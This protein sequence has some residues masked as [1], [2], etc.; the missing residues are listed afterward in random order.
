MKLSPTVIFLLIAIAATVAPAGAAPSEQSEPDSDQFM[1]TAESVEASEGPRGRVVRLDSNVTITRGGAT[2]TGD[3]GVYYEAEGHAIVYGNVTG[4]DGGRYV[5]CDTLDYFLATDSV[6][7]RGNASYSD[8]SGT[9]TADRIRMLRSEGVAVC[10][11]NVRSADADG[12]FQLTAGKLVYDFDAG[13]GRASMEPSLT[14][15]DDE[16]NLDASVSGDVIEFSTA[17]DAAFAFGDVTMEREDITARA[18][19]ASVVRDGGIE[20][21][22]DPLVEQ[23]G[24]GLTGDRITVSTKDGEVSRVVSVGSAT[25]TYVIEPDEAGEAPSRG[26]VS[27]DTLTMFMEDGTPVLTT[28]RGHASSE[29]QVGESGERN[30]VNSRAM[31]V[32]FTDGRIKRVA[33]R[34]RA[35][36]TYSFPPEGYEP[37]GTTDGIGDG[38]GDEATGRIADGIADGAT[39]G[40][41]APESLATDGSPEPPTEPLD[42]E[43]S[44]AADQ[45]DSLSTEPL[46]ALGAEAASDAPELETVAYQS[47]EIN[48]YVGRNRIVL[49]G[50]ARVDYEST[51]LLADD[52]VFDP[53]EQVLE[54]SGNPDL[55][56][57][58]DRLAGEHLTY[59]LEGKTGEIDGGVTTF[60]DGLYYGDH[61]V[62][63]ED[64][65]LEVGR[66][67]YT[68]CSNPEPHFS[69]VSHR[70][71]I[72]INDK[73]IA[74]PV[75]L[76]IGKMPV[77]ALPFY[78]FPIRKE[79]H[80]GFLLPQLELGIT[81]GEGRFVRNFGYYWAPSDY[82]DASVWADYYEQTKWIGHVETRYKLRYVL[83]GSV[84]ASFMEELLYNKRRWDLKFSHRQE[85]GRVWTAGAS[86][87]FRSDA[88]YA[89]DSNQSIQESVNR[90]LHSQLWVRG[91][92][93]SH[94]LGITVD[95]REQLDAE[96]VSELLPKA[97]LTATSQPVV[98]A[99]RELPGYAAWLKKVSFGWSARA[100]NDR[101][102]AGDAEVVHQGLGVNGSLRGT[103]KFLGWL[104]LSPRL[105][106][107]Q[108]WYDRDRSGEKFPGR[109]TYDA[110]L[111]ARTT[112]Y[113]T[114][115]PEA[116]GFSALRH[117]VEPSASFSWTPEF[118]Q[119][120]DESGADRFYSFSGFGSTPGSRR[121]LSLSVVNKLQAKL[122][123]GESER[124]ID[125]LLRFSSSTSYDLKKDERPWSDLVSGLELRPGPTVSMRW[126]ARH[127]AYGG[128]IKSST[129]T[130]SLDLRGSPSVATAEP[131]EDRVGRTDSPAE[132]LRR[133]LASRS[134]GKLPGDK[135]WDASLAFRYSRGADPD[136]ASYWV[137][138][139]VAFSPSRHWRLNYAV[140]YDLKESE[141]A[142]QEYTIYRDLHCWEAQLTR[143]Y[144]DG[145]WQY[146]FRISVKAL[147]EIQAESGRKFLSRSIR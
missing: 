49:S 53:S 33:F 125:N 84:E 63:E 29:H 135:I 127:D 94:S 45:P 66:G 11:G 117:I 139:G 31:D 146:Y 39:G 82:W 104:N 43:W 124:K 35:T 2:L 145:E 54:A 138:G 97:E 131:W 25:A 19:A 102:R 12:T 37:D 118:P 96:T 24:D 120:F 89:S 136:N 30:F 140:H 86:G 51:V 144:Y 98:A 18:R 20:L 70:M 79:R 5:A 78:V 119:Y 141:V 7:L 27:G 50:S 91:R 26:T 100:V 83:S 62:R 48:Y 113:G 1:I 56:E 71:K 111:S 40:T 68:T 28:V 106:F 77:L 133:E 99:D 105:S 34:G 121:S 22:G 128:D 95:R 17:A 76:Y 123:S 10:R 126:N 137:D 88:T 122:G 81:E 59:D 36:G 60:E 110:G 67:T 109:F 69:L 16:G 92:W 15:F 87:D 73:V 93:S 116:L 142:S 101:D 143:R 108:N 58:S 75:I 6:L 61:I 107:T 4:E 134:L 74:K 72:Y 13:G 41:A 9:T 130:A 38:T 85:L 147:P 57:Q 32:L 129:V 80:S 103:G 132:E 90:S 3:L 47:D 23:G 42:S 114:F 112:V 55:R 14:T 115:F 65:T 21:T 8:T 46:D 64:G 44:L 52:I